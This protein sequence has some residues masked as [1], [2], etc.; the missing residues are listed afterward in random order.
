MKSCF[1]QSGRT[2]TQ[3]SDVLIPDLVM[4]PQPEGDIGV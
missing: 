1:E 2:Y 4:D 3:I